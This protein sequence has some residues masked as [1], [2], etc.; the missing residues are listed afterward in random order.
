MA[1]AHFSLRR[2]WTLAS[3]AAVALLTG[4]VSSSP[5]VDSHFGEAVRAA[6]ASQT[7]NPQAS[8]NRDPVLGI[9]GRAGAAAMERYQESFKTP[10]KTFEIQGIGGTSGQ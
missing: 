9:D 1:L 2:G 5:V 10:P 7:L 3:L 8:A 6:R 4:C